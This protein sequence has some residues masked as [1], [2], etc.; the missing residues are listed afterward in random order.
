MENG[1]GNGADTGYLLPG[2]VASAI[3]TS[4]ISARQ[5]RPRGRQLAS[6]EGVDPLYSRTQRLMVEVIIS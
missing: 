4:A 5:L 3:A 2:V 1:Y 6:R